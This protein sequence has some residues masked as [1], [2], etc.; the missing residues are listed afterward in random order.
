MINKQFVSEALKSCI[1]MD[2]KPD[3][4]R[5]KSSSCQDSAVS[6]LIHDIFGGKIL[7]TRKKK[8][9]HFYNMIDGERIDFTAS[10]IEKPAD[11][12][13]FEDIPSTPD[14]TSGYFDKI[15]YSVF[16]IRFVRA[17]EE[18]V[19]LDNFRSGITI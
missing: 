2:T 8:G 10:D 17:F 14:E 15:D 9:W 12:K 7:K 5:N 4:I 18:A 19:G 13:T 3:R 1:T 16:F 11:D 6:M